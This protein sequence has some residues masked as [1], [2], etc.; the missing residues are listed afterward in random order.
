MHPPEFWITDGPLGQALDPIGRLYGAVTTWRIKHGAYV[1]T[2]VPVISV[3]NLTVGG[4]GKTPVARD[5]VPRLTN[6]GFR[7]AVVLRGYGGQLKGPARVDPNIH[8]ALDVGDEA[9]LHSRDGMT[10][11]A[12]QRIDGAYEAT[13]AGAKA[14]ILD[15]AHQHASMAK[16]LS[17]VVI[18]GAMGFGNHRIVPAG[19]LR[20][21]VRA[22]LA[23]TDAV[24][25]MGDDETGVAARLPP[26]I[27]VLHG[28]LQPG[29]E[30]VFLNQRKVVAFAGLGRPG[31]FFNTLVELGAKVV[32]A[33]PFDDHH[34]YQPADIQSI[35]DEAFALE[36]LPVTTE[37]DAMRLTP[38]QRQQV[39]VLR[40]AVQWK[41]AAALDALLKR[42]L[43]G[44]RNGGSGNGG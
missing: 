1:K 28:T 7:P 33:H 16:D 24:V 25:I 36:A 19:P 26:D 13:E 15:D 12:R 14:I 21:P 4:T 37:K 30:S 5:L 32:A 29:P 8:R 38:D 9:L 44:S 20:E 2:P 43:S 35:L 10:W 17:L 11:V 18:D 34:L 6:L 31:K 39:N 23:R 22:G 42:T 27:P 40:V 3:G 41:D